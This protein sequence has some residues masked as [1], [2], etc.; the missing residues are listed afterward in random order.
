MISL[1]FA[2]TFCCLNILLLKQSSCRWFQTLMHHH[3]NDMLSKLI[4]KIYSNWKASNSAK[5][6]FCDFQ[7]PL[8]FLTSP[9]ITK[10]VGIRKLQNVMWCNHIPM[11][12]I[13][14]SHMHNK[15]FVSCGCMMLYRVQGYLLI[16]IKNENIPIDTTHRRTFRK[17]EY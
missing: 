9:L 12:Y 8:I 1:M 10:Y 2:Y 16:Y 7:T 3:F 11:I 6:H 5:Q 13:T 14:A 15:W 17:A 4:V